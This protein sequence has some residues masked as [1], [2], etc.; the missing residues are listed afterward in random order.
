MDVKIER[1]WEELLKEEFEKDYFKAILR[2]LQE[3]QHEGVEVFPQ[4]EDIFNAFNSVPLSRLKVVILGQD[5]YH[6]KGQA[7]GLSFSVPQSVKIPPSL[8]NIYKELEQDVNFIRPQHGSLQAWAEEG[9][10]LLNAHLTVEANKPNS[11]KAIGWERFTD[12]VIEKLSLERE[13]LVF[14]LWGKFAQSKVELIDGER[15]KILTAAHPSPF[16]AHSGFFNCRHFSKT[17]KYLRENG[18]SE[19]NWQL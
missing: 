3:E 13:N 16:S 18:C 6:S 1:S 11:H 15:H 19:I 7:H 9:V 5:P 8:R 4:E 12:S 14:L 2:F 10:L 17:N